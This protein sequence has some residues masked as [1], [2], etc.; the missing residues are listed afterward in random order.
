M[1]SKKE[2]FNTIDAAGSKHYS[3]REVK[4]IVSSLKKEV[5]KPN[6]LK[7]GD[8]FTTFVGSKSR[9]VVICRVLGDIVVG[10]PLSTTEDELTLMPFKSRFL[11]ENYMSKML[12]TSTYEH[13]MENFA[14]V[15]D[16]N[17]VLNKAMKELKI[18]YNIIL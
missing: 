7:K 5:P 8:I 17:G 12:I 3:G 6:T 10:I 1:P 15:F 14:G 16:N 18:F 11:G 9:P 2:I 13:A 4:A